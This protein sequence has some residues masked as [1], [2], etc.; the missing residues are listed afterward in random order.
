MVITID[1]LRADHVGA[2]GYQ[3]A[4]DAQHRRARARRRALR[5]RVR[6]GAAHLVLGGVDADRQV[7]PDAGAAGA[8]RGATSRSPTVLRHDGWRTAAFFPPAV[9]FVDAQK[10]KAYADT[11]FNFEY[12]KFEYLDAE[13]RVDQ[14]ES[15]FDTVK[16]AE[17]VRLGPLLRAA[18]ALRGARRASRSARPTSIATT[19]RSPTSTARSGGC[20]PTCTACARARSSSWPPTTARSST[21]T[22]G[23]TTAR[24]CTTSSCTSR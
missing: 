13:R 6:A 1:A 12:V 11:Y 16:P 17:G 8:R 21:S 2:Y 19:A 4:D 23:A 22:A 3:R 20:S 7:L 15:Y 14:I 18:R 10:L 24:R 5:A 9:F